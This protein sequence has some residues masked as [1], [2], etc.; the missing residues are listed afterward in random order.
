MKS[1][2]LLVAL[3]A[4]GC[5]VPLKIDQSKVVPPPPGF[6]EAMA[7]V[8]KFYGVRHA[9]TVYFYGPEAMTCAGGTGYQSAVGNCV[10]GEQ[11]EGVIVLATWP[12]YTFSAV[13]PYSTIRNVGSLPHE[14]AHHASDERGEDGCADH[15]CH[16][17]AKGGEGEQVTRLLAEAGL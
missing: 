17:F 5:G 9:P 1:L 16:W 2:G 7:K 11:E 10:S 6:D 13:P 15:H 12:G 3:L 8:V 14:V 4:V